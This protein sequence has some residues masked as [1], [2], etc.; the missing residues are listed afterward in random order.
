MEKKSTEPTPVVTQPTP[1]TELYSWG[2]PERLYKKRNREFYST[3]AALVI[4]LSVILLFAKEFLL[5]AVIM[6]FGFVSYALASVKPGNTTHKMTNRGVR[7]AG[8]IYQWHMISRHWWE[9]KWKQDIL[10]IEM[11]GQFPHKLLLL[12]GNGDKKKI[13]S[14]LS[15]YSVKDKPPPTWLDKS[16]DW[17]QKKVPLESSDN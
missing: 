1:E 6:S 7:T 16:A 12:L 17:L 15:K 8:R 13:E 14:V 3:V 9:T 4:L 5:I 2:A 10:H 11:P